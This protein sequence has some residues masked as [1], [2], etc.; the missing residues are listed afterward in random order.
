[1]FGSRKV[2]TAVV[3]TDPTASKYIPI[4]R[5]PVDAHITIESAYL[6]ADTT[7]AAHTT[8]YYAVHLVNGGTGGTATTGISSTVS[9]AAGT[10]TAN[11]PN[12]FTI[13]DGSGKLND[14]EWLTARH[15][16][17]GSVGDAGRIT[18]VVEYVR[19]LGEKAAA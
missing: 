6:C 13:T 4:L 8:D 18:I 2:V 3:Y 12:T 17:A 7:V 19:G 14:G 15:T 9:V 16:D 1:M 5:A 10:I 11:V